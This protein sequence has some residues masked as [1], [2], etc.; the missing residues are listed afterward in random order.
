[1]GTSKT[2]PG[3]VG[4]CWRKA[5]GRQTAWLQG[6]GDWGIGSVAEGYLAAIRAGSHEPD[7]AGWPELRGA[8]GDTAGALV[9]TVDE[10]SRSGP[11][12][13]LDEGLLRTRAVGTEDKFADA[14]A[15]RVAGPG[16]RLVDVI[17]RT[18]ALRSARLLY[19]GNPRLR[20]ELRYLERAAEE[21][22]GATLRA[23]SRPRSDPLVDG[24]VLG[25][26]FRA[27]LGDVLGE[28]VLALAADQ[29]CVGFPGAAATVQEEAV[30]EWGHGEVAR[31]VPDPYDVWR[32]EQS[33]TDGRGRSATDIAKDLVPEAVRQLWCWEAASD[34]TG[35]ADVAI[36][37]DVAGNVAG[38]AT[39]EATGWTPETA[40][41]GG[42][43]GEATT[44][45]ASG[46]STTRSG[47]P[48]RPRRA[49]LR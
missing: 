41:P 17:M 35:A 9:A 26:L 4:D 28:T 3:P 38:T 10:I 20:E 40:Q 19:T 48:T 16:N 29:L 2:F 24:E 8:T 22:G 33:G 1:M 5:R 43:T 21:G 6:K 45:A 32:Q 23:A 18:A 46:A 31:L 42:E 44:A 25:V 12:T 34:P 7:S 47:V 37:G 14:V 27:F 11:A 30:R 13:V 36:A 49:G 15:D 39:R